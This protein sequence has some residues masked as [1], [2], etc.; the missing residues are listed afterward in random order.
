MADSKENQHCDLGSDKVN[1]NFTVLEKSIRV[2]EKS[3]KCVSEKGYEPCNDIKFI[4]S[5]PQLVQPFL[6]VSNLKVAEL[7]CGCS[8][9]KLA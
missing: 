7:L 1:V 8:L 9:G 4:D 3:W 6:P 5:V 2:L